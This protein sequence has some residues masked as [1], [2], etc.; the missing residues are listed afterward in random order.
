MTRV[1]TASQVIDSL[2]VETALATLREGF[3]RDDESS[4]PGQRAR[5]DLPGP[6]TAT[7]LLPGL[8]PGIPAFTVK[9]N[10]KFP[11]ATPALRGVIGL[12]DINDGA[13]LALLDSATITAWRTGLAAALA[14]DALAQASS[15]TTVGVIG[16]GAQAALIVRGLASLR[17][18]DGLV[19][20]DTN[21]G[22]AEQFA[23]DHTP[24]GATVEIVQS[25]QA[26]AMQSSIVLLATWSR[27][28]LLALGDV[29][30][31][32][33]LTSVGA[34]E[35]G[36]CELAA[37]LLSS[38]SVFVD[39]FRLVSDVGALATAGISIEAAT[40]GEVLRG[41]RPGRSSADDITVY[42]PVGL[43]WLDLALAWSAFKS[44]E[45]HDS[46]LLVDFL[47]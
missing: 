9:M 22:A 25:A 39:D 24:D 43:P 1:I 36:K 3:L 35:P 5:T 46:G 18:V 45:A 12:F 19:I 29:R 26:V 37:D 8:V 41:E 30:A 33:H 13:L 44:A 34:D 2:D 47:S 32:Q 17:S 7:A 16:A 6:G 14:T 15:S 20:T 31:G 23:I 11:A 38:A 27:V 21:L 4:I 42:T 10:A 40:F 28:P